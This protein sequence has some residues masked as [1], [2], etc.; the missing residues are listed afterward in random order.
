MPNIALL[1]V[2]IL[3][4]LNYSIAKVVMTGGYLTP[5]A[6]IFLRVGVSTILFVFFH[7]LFIKEKMS[8]E[9]I[10]YSAFCSIFGVVINMLC[11]FEGIKHTSPL[12]AS[13]FMIMTPILVL[14]ISAIIIRERVSVRKLVGIGLGFVGAALLVIKSSVGHATSATFYGDM[15]V[16]LNAVS[17]AVYLVIAKRL[18]EKYHP[19]TVVKWVFFFGSLVIIPI[20]YRDI[21]TVSWISFSAE[22]WWSIAYVIFLVTFTTVLLNAYALSRVNPS[23]VG[24]YIFFQPLIAGLYS[25]SIGQEKLIL[26]DVIAAILLFFGVFLVI[27]EGVKR[28]GIQ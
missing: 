3:Y 12:H 17:F 23:T 9:D 1:L 19:L 18:L 13:L 25:I 24:F 26:N 5:K 7:S 11:F 2:A 6:F 27:F 22:I 14:I 20:G 10:L 4:G 28:S 8:T 21:M 15:M 16:I